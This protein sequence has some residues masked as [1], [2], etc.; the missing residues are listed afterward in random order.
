MA[1]VSWQRGILSVREWRKKHT[2]Y[3]ILNVNKRKWLTQIGIA[4]DSGASS[5]QQGDY[6]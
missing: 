6:P 5:Q 4:P 3:A 1:Y 2:P